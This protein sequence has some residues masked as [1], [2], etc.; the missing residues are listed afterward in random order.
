MMLMSMVRMKTYNMIFRNPNT[1]EGQIEPWINEK[2]EYDPC[3]K[4]P[5]IYPSLT[6]CSV[7]KRT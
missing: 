5:L 1:A 7:V 4:S 6:K 2:N 3:L